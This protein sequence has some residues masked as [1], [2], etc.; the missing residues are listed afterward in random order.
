ML[1]GMKG[2]THVDVAVFLLSTL[3]CFPCLIFQVDSLLCSLFNTLVYFV[4]QRRTG[5]HSR[6]RSRSKDR[7]SSRR[8]SS[9]ER[10]RRDGHRRRRSGSRDEHRHRRRHSSS[11]RRRHHS[12]SPDHKKSHTDKKRRSRSPHS[13]RGTKEDDSNASRHQ[14]LKS[15]GLKFGRGRST[16]VSSYKEQLKQEYIQNYANLQEAVNGKDGQHIKC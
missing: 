13:S 9:R 10:R 4:L 7:H 6:S 11:H 15:A 14:G 16:V 3:H 2:L 8:H 1:E 5:Q 12:R